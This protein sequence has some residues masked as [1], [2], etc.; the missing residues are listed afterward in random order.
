MPVV[1]E[2]D[3]CGDVAGMVVVAPF[4]SDA[5]GT[6]RMTTATASP[7]PFLTLRHALA[8][9]PTNATIVMYPGTYAADC[10]LALGASAAHRIIG[11]SVLVPLARPSV[12]DCAAYASSTSFV[13]VTGANVTVRQ[14]TSA[15]TSTRTK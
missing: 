13:T 15:S 11:L 4:G 9:S 10:G 12:I 2:H 6:G 8:V 14:W 7:K 3:A 5:M 1:C